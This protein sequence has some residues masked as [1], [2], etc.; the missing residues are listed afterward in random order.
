MCGQWECQ[1]VWLVRDD[2][3]SDAQFRLNIFSASLL[4]SWRS[5][6]RLRDPRHAGYS[7][8]PQAEWCWLIV[9]LIEAH[10]S[11]F[12]GGRGK[13]DVYENAARGRWQ[14]SRLKSL[15]EQMV[16]LLMGIKLLF[17]KYNLLCFLYKRMT[18]KKK[19]VLFISAE[20]MKCILPVAPSEGQLSRWGM[21][22]QIGNERGDGAI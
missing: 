20:Y 2:V 21:G 6:Y 14:I 7:H 15:S 10:K 5:L 11:P 16:R 12:V 3:D 9:W 22:S 4:F 13:R 1:A 18:W 17:Y 8:P 19:Q